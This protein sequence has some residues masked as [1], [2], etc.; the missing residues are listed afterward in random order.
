MQ[1]FLAWVNEPSSL[2][3]AVKSAIAHLWFLTI[4]PFEDGNGRLS[5]SI[6]EYVLNQGN[7]SNLVLFSI[8][9]Q[10]KM[11]QQEYYEQLH[12][13]QTSSMG[14]TVWI[15]WYLDLIKDALLEVLETIG[16]IL[17]V[18]QFY[19]TLEKLSLNERQQGMIRRLTTDFYGDLTT[20][21]WTGLTKC[22]HDTAIRDIKDLMSK[23]ILKRSGA[24][25]RSTSYQLILSYGQEA[26][27]EEL[28]DEELLAISKGS[29]KFHDTA[30]KDLRN[31]WT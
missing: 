26:S 9:T 31:G 20:Q 3:V 17:Q 21:K 4:N 5:R 11:R 8:S 19:R 27:D 14:C 16:K 28:A 24:G 1:T 30:Y 18:Q 29:F 23:G 12:K 2:P 15:V 13:A 10:V 25:G 22:S 6:S 7:T